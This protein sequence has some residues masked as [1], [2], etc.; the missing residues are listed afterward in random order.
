VIYI[1]VSIAAVGALPADQLA[2]AEAPLADALEKGA[3]L[4]WAASLMALG[5]CVAITSVVLT[6]LYGQ[7]RIMFSMSRDGLVPPRLATVNERYGRP[8]S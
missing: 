2:K 7:T 4:S 8:R 5:A 6:I 1:L 3:G